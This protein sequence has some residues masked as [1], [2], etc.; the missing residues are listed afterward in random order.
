MNV[1]L[2]ILS[3]KALLQGRAEVDTFYFTSSS[4]RALF[5]SWGHFYTPPPLLRWWFCGF[6]FL[7]SWT[8]KSGPSTVYFCGISPWFTTLALVGFG[9]VSPN[10]RRLSRGVDNTYPIISI[11]SFNLFGAVRLKFGVCFGSRYSTTFTVKSHWSSIYSF[12]LVRQFDWHT[13]SICNHKVVSL[14]CVLFTQLE[15]SIRNEPLWTFDTNSRGT[16][17]KTLK[18]P[19][20]H[21][22][23]AASCGSILRNNFLIR[24]LLYTQESQALCGPK[25]FNLEH[26]L[27]LAFFPWSP[28]SDDISSD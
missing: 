14:Q 2:F 1:L 17:K 24:T 11:I 3:P 22:R 26:R 13:I 20:S 15:S 16:E 23:V 4:W 19:P 7:A 18:T 21:M 5:S 9:Q 8:G 10:R 27:R 12:D 25:V 6:F 28:L